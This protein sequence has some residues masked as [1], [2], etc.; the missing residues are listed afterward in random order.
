[1]WGPGKRLGINVS[2][3]A[4]I[5]EDIGNDPTSNLGFLG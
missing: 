2:N 3:M 5:F 4:L 1:M